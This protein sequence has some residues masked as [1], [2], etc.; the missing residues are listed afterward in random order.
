[1]GMAGTALIKGIGV[2]E[3]VEAL[4]GFYCYNLVVFHYSRAVENRLEGQAFSCSVT[5][6]RSTPPAPALRRQRS[7]PIGS[8]SW[9]AR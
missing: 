2:E 1:M 5:S 8:A 3:I 6:W 7:W 9:A 4:D